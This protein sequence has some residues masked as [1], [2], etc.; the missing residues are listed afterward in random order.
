MDSGKKLCYDAV[1]L[2]KRGM[3]YGKCDQCDHDDLNRAGG[4]SS[5]PGDHGLHSSDGRVEDLPEGKIRLFHLSL[6]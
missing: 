2:R 5:D 3:R 6:K 4:R 1:S